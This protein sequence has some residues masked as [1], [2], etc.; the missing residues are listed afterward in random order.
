MIE[1]GKLGWRECSSCIGVVREGENLGFCFV[2][3][4]AQWWAEGLNRFNK[5]WEVFVWEESKCFIKVGMGGTFGTA[6]VISRL[7]GG[8]ALLCTVAEGRIEGLEYLEYDKAGKCGGE[9]VSF[10][11]TVFLEEE[12]K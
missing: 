1:V 2:E 5:D 9:G 12:V 10:G 8:S 6:T 11:K 4:Y 3:V 7:V